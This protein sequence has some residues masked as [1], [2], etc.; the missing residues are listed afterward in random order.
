[1]QLK[2]F[3]IILSCLALF[4]CSSIQM[5]NTP[6]RWQQHQQLLSQITNFTITGQLGYITPTERRSLNIQLTKTGT[7]SHLRLSTFLGQTVMKMTITPELSTIDSYEGEHYENKNPD[8]LIEQLIGL[9]IPISELENWLLG[10]PNPTDNYTFNENH[11]LSTVTNNA[12]EPWSVVY[13]RYQNVELN[14]DVIPLPYKLSLK[15]S[16]TKLHLVISKWKIKS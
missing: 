5:A 6:V 8:L 9:Q 7:T 15:H 1:M 16:A 11:T 14:Q 12:Q 13:R 10:L 3:S 4:G 2:F